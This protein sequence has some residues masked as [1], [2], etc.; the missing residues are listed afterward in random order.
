[1]NLYEFSGDPTVSRMRTQEEIEGFERK[2]KE[3]IDAFRSFKE[4]IEFYCQTDSEQRNLRNYLSAREFDSLQ[5]FF[6]STS[7]LFISY[8]NV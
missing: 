2:R 3:A 7:H 4:N 6:F 5:V 8:K 1:M